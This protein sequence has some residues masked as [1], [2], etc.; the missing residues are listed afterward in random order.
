MARAMATLDAAE[1]PSPLKAWKGAVLSR[2]EGSFRIQIHGFEHAF[3]G[4]ELL[5]TFFF[6]VAFGG[7]ASS[8][9]LMLWLFF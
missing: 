4:F 8:L 2:F 6:A 7:F 3:D 9:T 1:A 5:E